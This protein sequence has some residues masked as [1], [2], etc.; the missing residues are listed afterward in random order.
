MPL[1][2]RSQTE[3]TTVDLTTIEYG[4]D[5]VRVEVSGE[6]AEFL[7]KDRKRQQAQ[8][9]SDRRHLSTGTFEKDLL[10]SQRVPTL[11]DETYLAVIRKMELEKLQS[12][13][14]ELKVDERTLIRLYYYESWSMERI[15]NHFG[16][17]KMAVSKRHRKITKKLRELMET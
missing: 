1:T 8:E 6:V 16:I 2:I 9:R 17:S 7:E 12:A 15:G 3:R 11:V 5:H 4:D 14:Q 13:L 10:G